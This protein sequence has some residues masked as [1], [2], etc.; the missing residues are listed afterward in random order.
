[1]SYD[2]ILRNGHV[3]DPGQ[4]IDGVF[5]IAFSDGSVAALAPS[6][7]GEAADVRD[8]SGLHVFPGLIDLHTHVYWGGTF[9]GVDAT[10]L[11][12]RSGMTTA[13]DAGS[14][15][16]A[17]IR[18][19]LE[20]CAPMTPARI[21]AFINLAVT[22]I[23]VDEGRITMDEA[24]DLRL[25][26]IQHC[27]DAA[28][29][30]RQSVVGV[31]IRVGASTT[32]HLGAMPLHMAVRA[33]ELA[34]LPVMVHIGAGMPPRLEDIV[35]PLR[36]GD[37]LT[38]F[39]TPKMNSPLTRDGFLR[40]CMIAARERGVIMDV[41]HGAGSFGFHVAR[42][43]LE[44]G[45]PPDVISSDVHSG[46]VD[47]PA[48]DVLAIMSKY[49]AL[50]LPL[51]DIVRAATATPAAVCR[52]PDLGSLAPGSAGDAAV[53]EI[54]RERTVFRDSIGDTLAGDRR[55]VARGVIIGGRWWR[56]AEPRREAA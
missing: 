4:G 28:K 2:L 7:G 10:M 13:V 26:D 50:G 45:F 55:F 56:D 23:F 21:L 44:L 27:V 52:R 18:G 49:L 11:A 3:V 37:I 33:G 34:G 5:D 15:G 48:Q 8:L 25:L 24:E 53:V 32:K 31:K 42:R 14:A 9:L 51:I 12:A 41:G 40:D 19:L 20:Q 46:C 6:L 1:M 35:D 30:H 54:R 39:C 43:M 22:G 36:K 29:R 16:A 47:G 17:N 38:H